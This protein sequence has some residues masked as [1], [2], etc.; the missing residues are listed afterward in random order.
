MILE[1]VGRLGLKWRDLARYMEGRSPQSLKNRYY[2]LQRKKSPTWLWDRSQKK[3][4]R[5]TERKRREELKTE[6][7]S[8]LLNEALSQ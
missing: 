8:A 7:L 3:E 5:A 2:Y 1:L 4:D 6:Q